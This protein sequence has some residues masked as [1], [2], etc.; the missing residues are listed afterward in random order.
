MQELI[1]SRSAMGCNILELYF[2]P[3]HLDIFPA[4][5]EAVFDEHYEIFLQESEYV[6]WLLLESY[7]GDTN[8]RKLEAKGEEMSV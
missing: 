4:N 2:L 3:S 7:K 6:D 8:R 5:M 1:S